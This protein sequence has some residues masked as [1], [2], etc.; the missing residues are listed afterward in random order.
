MST[1]ALVRHGAAYAQQLTDGLSSWLE[2]KELTLDRARGMLAVP[3]DV[4]ADAYERAGYVAALERAK[5]LYGR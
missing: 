5:A 1:S 3:T 4:P 2:R